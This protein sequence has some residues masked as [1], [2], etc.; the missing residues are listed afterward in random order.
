MF[1]SQFQGVRQSGV[2]STALGGAVTLTVFLDFSSIR[3][4][5]MLSYVRTGGRSRHVRAF[6]FWRN[7]RRL[8]AESASLCRLPV[9]AFAR[10]RVWSHWRPPVTECRSSAE[11]MDSYGRLAH[12]SGGG[13]MFF[14]T[15]PARAGS[16]STHSLH[17]RRGVTGG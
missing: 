12:A 15:H 5:A 10:A 16:V 11:L 3:V 6:V 2:C 8:T 7:T 13:A 4:L 14:R 1:L 9:S 17:S